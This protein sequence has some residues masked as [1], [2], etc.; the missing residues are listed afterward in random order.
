M[1]IEKT[2]PIWQG[3]G[4]PNSPQAGLEP[5]TFSLTAKHA[6]DCVIEECKLL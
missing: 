6:T 4:I 2:L 5:T 1:S 3:L